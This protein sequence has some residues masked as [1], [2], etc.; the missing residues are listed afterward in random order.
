MDD[1]KE[2]ELKAIY[3]AQRVIAENADSDAISLITSALKKYSIDAMMIVSRIKDEESFIEKCIRKK[4][5]SP[6]E[7][8]TDLLGIRIVLYS[9]Y[10]VA[11]AEAAVRGVLEINDKK[12]PNYLIAEEPSTMGYRSLH[13]VGSLTKSDNVGDLDKSTFRI[14]VQ[15]RTALQH[16]WAELE[17]KLS[18]KKPGSLPNFLQRRLYLAAAGLEMVDQAFGDIV[19]YAS[20]YTQDVVRK[21]AKYTKDD[22]NYLATGALFIELI[23]DMGLG[24]MKVE[25]PKPTTVQSIVQDLKNYGIADLNDLRELIRRTDKIKLKAALQERE[26]IRLRGLGIYLLMS[27]N[28]KQYFE[29]VFSGNFRALSGR[30]I[31]LVKGTNPDSDID[32]LLKQHGVGLALIPKQKRPH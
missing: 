27:D 4:Y 24:H 10:D 16:A 30:L 20:D 1:N 13:L 5:T 3:E 28:P 29:Q 9:E 25:E 26:P 2:A 22:V 12:S 7:Q 11:N 31:E 32:A 15:I 19:R 18:Y 14:E 23:N 6:A 21:D 17:H 8:V